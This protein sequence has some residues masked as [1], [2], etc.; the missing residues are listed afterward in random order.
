MNKVAYATISDTKVATH[1]FLAIR[2]RK[3]MD[4]LD[5]LRQFLERDPDDAFSRHALALEWVKRGDDAAARLEFETV[6]LR[7][8][9]YVGSYYHLGKLLERTGEPEAALQTYREGILRAVA[10]GDNH[11]A[12]ELRAAAEALED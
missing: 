10:A 9:G 6:L 11:A 12:G 5:S 8:P 1:H 7:N 3:K 4:R 2:Q